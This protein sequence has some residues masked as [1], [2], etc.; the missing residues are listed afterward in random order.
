MKCEFSHITL[1]EAL[2]H[3]VLGAFEEGDRNVESEPPAVTEFVP[4]EELLYVPHPHVEHDP[5]D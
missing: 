4:I 3:L 2:E 5:A 1:E